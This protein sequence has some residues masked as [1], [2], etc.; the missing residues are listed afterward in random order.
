M[1]KLASIILYNVFN[2]SYNKVSNTSISSLVYKRISNATWSLRLR[3]VCNFL[4]VSPIRLIKTDSTKLWISSCASSKT[5]VP[6]AISALILFNSI[7]NLHMLIIKLLQLHVAQDLTAL[8]LVFVVI[9]V[10]EVHIRRY[11]YVLAE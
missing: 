7:N 10:V 5:R 8:V 2:K 4:P 1:F 9:V 11:Q 3:P 6:Q